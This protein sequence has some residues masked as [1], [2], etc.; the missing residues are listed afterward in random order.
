[1]FRWTPDVA[2][3]HIILFFTIVLAKMFV[4]Y[5]LAKIYRIAQDILIAARVGAGHSKLANEAAVD[6][7]VK[8]QI[9]RAATVEAVIKAKDDMIEKAADVAST[10][11]TETPI[12][13]LTVPEHLRVVIAQEP[14]KAL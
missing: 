5:W 8:L 11:R 4:V 3:G 7:G 2:T 13:G 1:M 14:A 10:L 9:A 12:L 6:N